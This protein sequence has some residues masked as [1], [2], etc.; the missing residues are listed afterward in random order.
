MSP[1]HRCLCL[2]IHGASAPDTHS[3]QFPEPG[4]HPSI[5][6]PQVVF[7]RLR[8]ASQ[9]PAYT[10]QFTGLMAVLQFQLPACS[11]S[12][13]QKRLWAPNTHA[14]CDP[15]S[16]GCPCSRLPMHGDPQSISQPSQV[17]CNGDLGPEMSQTD[18][19][20]QAVPYGA[21]CPLAWQLLGA[22]LCPFFPFLAEPSFGDGSFWGASFWKPALLQGEDFS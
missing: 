4:T 7:P 13:S 21:T 8:D 10:Q 9:P 2:V 20:R 11:D 18:C 1:S 15:C 17:A 14:C 22:T 6:Y 19:A 12:Q 3:R 16:L 5:R